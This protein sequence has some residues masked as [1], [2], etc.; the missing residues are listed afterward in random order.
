LIEPIRGFTLLFGFI[1]RTNTILPLY[2]QK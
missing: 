1:S 2:Y